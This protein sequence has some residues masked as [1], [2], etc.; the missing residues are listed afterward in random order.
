MSEQLGPH[1]RAVLEDTAVRPI[2]VELRDPFGGVIASWEL[3]E[4]HG[5][6]G[7]AWTL[8]AYL[9]AL[10]AGP[11]TAPFVVPGMDERAPFYFHIERVPIPA[12]TSVD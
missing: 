9:E 2:M 5:E 6:T 10:D 11:V 7:G 12:T 8:G 4:T 1:A 3:G